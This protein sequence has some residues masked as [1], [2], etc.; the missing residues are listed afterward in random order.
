MI[1][2]RPAWLLESRLR[3]LDFH[4]L[5]QPRSWF[6]RALTKLLPNGEAADG[7]RSRRQPHQLLAF[8]SFRVRA[9]LDDVALTIQRQITGHTKADLP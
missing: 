1:G 9:A 2:A 8:A 3:V 4:N 5:L 6:A 7:K